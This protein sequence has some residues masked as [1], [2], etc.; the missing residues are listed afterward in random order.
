MMA[1]DIIE[2][3]EDIGK[4]SAP[5]LSPAVHLAGETAEARRASILQMIR[6]TV[7]PRRLEFTAS[8][9]TLLAIEVNSSRITDVYAGST[10][11]I[12][13]FETESREDLVGKLAR[14][15]SDLAAS[16]P[17]IQLVSL[18]PDG[19]LEA[20]DVGITFSEMKKAC[21]AITLATEPRVSVVSDKAIDAKS[22]GPSDT[23]S[24]VLAQTFFAGADRFGMG[25]VLTGDD[26]GEPR[27]EGACA[28][29]QP[30]HPDNELLASF[31]ND[32]AG[33]DADSADVLT[34]PQLIV[35]RPSGGKGAAM[36]LLRDGRNTTVA[37][38]DARKLGA[39][40]NLWKSLRGNA[41]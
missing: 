30:L 17:D 8:S 36:A 41:Q 18:Q 11:T 22:E 9:G 3:L 16:A 34:H 6:G 2:L 7:L 1:T 25:H 24:D 5:R 39:V 10:G 35:M 31:V 29:N 19:P 33:W 28:D 13:D 32:L 4:A 37:V 40:V 23:G 21:A 27:Y 12:P 20:D 26:I 38:H 14:L 15:V